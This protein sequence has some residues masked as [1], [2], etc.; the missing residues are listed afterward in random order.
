MD[1]STKLIL[2]V[3]ASILLFAAVGWFI[4][5]PT[6]APLFPQS[7]SGA[8]AQ[9]PSLPTNGSPQTPNI[10]NL[11]GPEDSG[12]AQGSAAAGGSSAASFV[13]SQNPDTEVIAALVRRAGVL[14]ER[15]ES[16]ASSDGFTN[17]ADA[18]LDVSPS[19]ASQFSALQKML[20]ARYPKTGALYLTTARRLAAQGE[21]DAIRSATFQVT[22]QLQ[23]ITRDM[24]QAE[25][26]REVSSY[27][28]ATVIFTNN[29]TEWIASG[30]AA[31]PFTP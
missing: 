1:R 20:Q 15:V 6:I 27:R 10:G 12:A 13:P 2:L 8:A 4:V 18:Q 11:G 9:P 3:I 19:L 30:Y 7:G 23:L 5:W 28:E 25:G 22:V 17:L 24:A 14:A 29:G 16:G 26:S 31:K 21:S